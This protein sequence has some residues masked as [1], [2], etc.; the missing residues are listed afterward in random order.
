MDGQQQF[1]LVHPDSGVVP[2]SRQLSVF[3]DEPG[4]SQHISCRNF[5]LEREREREFF[6][7]STMR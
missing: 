2:F 6:F 4:L 1:P 7:S 3:V 5:Y